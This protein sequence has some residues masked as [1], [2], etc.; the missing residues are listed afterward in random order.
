MTAVVVVMTDCSGRSDDGQGGNLHGH[1]K[2]S[3]PF[4]VEPD[5]EVRQA[6]V[7]LW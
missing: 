3:A 2:T 7:L 6:N 4:T 5:E 1:T